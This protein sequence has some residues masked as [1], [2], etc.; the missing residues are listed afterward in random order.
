M[1]LNITNIKIN[2]TGFVIHL[3]NVATRKF[4]ITCVVLIVIGMHDTNLKDNASWQC[5]ND[6]L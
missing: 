5:Y 4:K 2:F 1:G 3:K 6:A